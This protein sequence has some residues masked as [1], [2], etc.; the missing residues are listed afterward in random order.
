MAKA[1]STTEPVMDPDL[2]DPTRLDEDE[3]EPSSPLDSLASRAAD[4]VDGAAHLA[5]S[6]PAG[7]DQVAT[8]TG[9]AVGEAQRSIRRG[10]DAM[11]LGGASLSAGVALG[12]LVGGAPRIVAGLALLPATALAM[13]LADRRSGRLE[14]DSGLLN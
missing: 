10:S 4:A 11:L 12:L 7:V 13:A 14:R 6:L 3:Q 9:R 1:I 5:R 2:I 8:S